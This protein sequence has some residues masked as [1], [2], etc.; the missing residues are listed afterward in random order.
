MKTDNV[1]E[2]M[3]AIVEKRVELYKGDFYDYDIDLIHEYETHEFVW[4]VRPTG[5]HMVFPEMTKDKSYLRFLYDLYKGPNKWFYYVRI[6]DDGS[7]EVTLSE[8]RCDDF[9]FRMTG[10]LAGQGDGRNDKR[11]TA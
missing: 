8:K 3:A 11:R 5:T 2:T 1:L 6:N 10:L 9:A 4:M 7:G